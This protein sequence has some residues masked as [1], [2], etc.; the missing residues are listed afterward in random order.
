M[1]ELASVV[2]AEFSLGA[3]R[4]LAGADA[5]IPTL[6][7]RMRRKELVEPTGTYWGD[8]PVHRFH[9]VLIRDAAYRR[10]LKTT[11][12]DLH[13]RVGDVDRR[14]C[15]GTSS[16]STRRRSRSTTSR[17]TATARSS[18]SSTTRPTGLGRRAAE[19]LRVAAKRA[20]DRDDLASAGALARRALAVLPTADADDRADLLVVA[21]ECFLASGDVGAGAP[22]VDELRRSGRRRRALGAWAACFEAQ[23]V[24]LTDPD[25]LRRR[26]RDGPA[27]RP[28]TLQR[29]G[30]GA[31][32]AKAHQVRAGLLARLGRVG[33]AEVELDLALGAARA[34]DDRR[35]VTAVLGAAP[36]AA[37]FGPS[38]V[39]RAGGRC[40]DVVRL[41]RITTASPSVE[42]TSMRCQA[43]LEALRGRFDVSR[44]MLASAR[45]LAR[46]ARSAARTAGDRPLHRHGRADRRRCRLR[47][48]RRCAPRTTDSARSA[49]APTPARPPRCSRRALLERGDV[50][51][52][53]AMAT[54]S[55]ELA[56]QNLKTAIAWRVARAEVLAARGDVA[57][58]VAL[59]EAAVEIAAATDL[60]LDHADACVALADLRERA[61]DAAGARAARADALRLYEAKGATVPA[62]RLRPTG[63][64]EKPD[65]AAPARDRPGPEAALTRLDDGSPRP[66]V[67]LDN[68]ARRS[69]LDSIAAINEYLRSGDRSGMFALAAACADDFVL[70]DRRAIVA[71]PD[72]TRGSL[73]DVYATM[74]AQGYVRM[75]DEPIAIRGERLCLT[76]RTNATAA[77]D[78]SKLLSMAEL[79]EHGLICRVCL[80]DGDALEDA[81][82]DLDARYVAGEGAE[83]AHVLRGSGR[84]EAA[85]MRNDRPALLAT[86][87]PDYT[88]VD[89][90]SLGYDAV[91]RESFIEQALVRAEV[92]RDD[93]TVNRLLRV[94]GDV[95]LVVQD[96][97]WITPEGSDYERRSCVV[98]ARRRCGLGAP[99]RM[100]R[101]GPL[102]QRRR[103]ASTSW[104]R[105][106]PDVVSV[107]DIA[108]TATRAF[109]GGR[110]RTRPA[111]ST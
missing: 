76:L 75:D 70:E 39:A 65:A 107:P 24:G 83:H 16:A 84:W 44:S 8:E 27:R 111:T 20:L 73:G 78:E 23:L 103:R 85:V 53:D 92:A 93:V 74:R 101:R 31:G 50:D 6:L 56:G 98:V 12:A 90:R 5:P 86:M 35:R 7:E 81:M 2:G 64:S 72:Q 25:G 104:A 19:L 32:E 18:G 43:V 99:S 71:M 21:C 33:D 13:E 58:G 82:T 95:L 55:E 108:N 17:R 96:Q 80:Y 105:H 69:N 110:P 48:S 62:E 38:P 40:L 46:G 14:E 49:S 102:R 45:D 29:L 106:P 94:I 60:I 88:M 67:V 109:A 59:G 9:H 91:D 68:A 57:R 79:D 3:L 37:L 89:H 41:L 26:R 4:E 51:D 61:H 54:A 52:A 77:G 36:H 87:A 100:V 15:A 30:D 1:L 66:R 11:R 10:L 63:P 28:T 97:R 42:A 34:S 47:R 22:L